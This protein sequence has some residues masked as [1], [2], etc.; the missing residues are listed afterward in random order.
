MV[1]IATSRSILTTLDISIGLCKT[2]RIQPL[3]L[4]SRRFGKRSVGE[5]NPKDAV[6]SNYAD[7]N[8]LRVPNL[9]AIAVNAV[10]ASVSV[11]L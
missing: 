8:A 4:V 9:A 6:V 3:S 2:W 5:M 10:V 7:Q 11:R 1:D